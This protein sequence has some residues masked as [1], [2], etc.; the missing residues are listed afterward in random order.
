[1]IQR[2]G[3]YRRRAALPTQVERRRWEN[4]EEREVVQENELGDDGRRV[5]PMTRPDQ[6]SH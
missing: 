5:K 6:E 3:R 2:F 4:D 1:M